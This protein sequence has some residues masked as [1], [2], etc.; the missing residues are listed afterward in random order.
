MSCAM[1]RIPCGCA[2]PTRPRRLLAGRA[3]FWF[4]PRTR[5]NDGY[6]LMMGLNGFQRNQREFVVL[7][8]ENYFHFEGPKAPSADDSKIVVTA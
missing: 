2:N 5:F 4:E 6:Y 3:A 8:D 7:A 1:R